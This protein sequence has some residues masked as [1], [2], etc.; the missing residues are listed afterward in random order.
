MWEVGRIADASSGVASYPVT[1][2]FEDTDG[3]F[4]VGATV[5]VEITYDEVE[6]VVQ[7]P[8]LAVTTEDGRRRSP[9]GPTTATRPAPSRPA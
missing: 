2:A 5:S 4:N 1:V 6:D 7:V 3:E 8:A 9:C